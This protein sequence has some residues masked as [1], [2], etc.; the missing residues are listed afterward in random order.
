MNDWPTHQGNNQRN[1]I[2]SQR[3]SLPMNERWTYISK[4]APQPAWPPP[5][6]KDPWHRHPKLNPRAIFDRAYHV[7]SDGELVFF[8]SSADEKIYCLN[9]EN[10]QEKWSFFTEGPV[11]LA[12]T[13]LDDKVY[14]G[15]DD[16]VVY[17]L[18]S[19]DGTLVWK[20]RSL[21]GGRRIPGNQ[22]I[23]SNTPVR[24]GVLI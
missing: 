18:K 8:A 5:A 3:L 21:A 14:I 11:R 24:T 13:I 23:V 16:G 4:H 2:T 9:A 7:V 10:G 17:C 20:Y 19:A 12:P 6:R 15:S 22:R 1:G